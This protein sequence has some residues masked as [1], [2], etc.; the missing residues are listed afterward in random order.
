MAHLM[1]RHNLPNSQQDYSISVQ[2]GPDFR[3]SFVDVDA[4]HTNKAPG[5]IAY[6][7]L[8]F[9]VTEASYLIERMMD[10]LAHDL[11]KSQNTSFACKTSSNQ[12]HFPI[13]LP[14]I[15]HSIVETMKAH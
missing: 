6:G 2:A 4:V 13:V 9:R 1:P 3:H 10:T 14:L 15:G 8:R 5:G 12:K 7:C 11:G